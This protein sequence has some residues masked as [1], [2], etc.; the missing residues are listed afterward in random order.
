MPAVPAVPALRRAGGA[1]GTPALP[2]R[3]DPRPGRAL[4][5]AGPLV[6][7]PAHGAS[8][9]CTG[10]RGRSAHGGR[11]RCTGRPRHGV[12]GVRSAGAVPGPRP[13][14]HG[15]PST[16]RV[17]RPATP[18]PAM[19]TVPPSTP[20][21]LIP[22]VPKAPDVRGAQTPGRAMRGAGGHGH[23]RGQTVPSCGAGGWLGQPPPALP[24][25]GLLAHRPGFSLPPGLPESP[26]CPHMMGGGGTDAR[27]PPPRPSQL[28]PP[29][30]SQDLAPT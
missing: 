11:R 4:R 22:K 16:R 2:P 12:P 18:G 27:P 3:G 14:V 15:M 9:G 1:G 24:S 10:P 26:P 5:G 28:E 21:C 17:Q 25:P 6:P 23:G 29:Q 7:H 30:E 19:P 8:P 13:R 20:G